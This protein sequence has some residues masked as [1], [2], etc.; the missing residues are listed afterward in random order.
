MFV[1]TERDTFEAMHTSFY[2]FIVDVGCMLQSALMPIERSNES[3]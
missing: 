1:E 2:G 3:F